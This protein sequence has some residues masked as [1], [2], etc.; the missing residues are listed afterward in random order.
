LNLP[1]GFA[2]PELSTVSFDFKSFESVKELA[3]HFWL[4]YQMIKVV[5]IEI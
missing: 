5:L 3:L 2:C 4:F 1:D